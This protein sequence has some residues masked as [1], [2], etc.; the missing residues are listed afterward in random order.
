MCGIAGIL[1]NNSNEKLIEKFQKISNQLLHRGPD[2]SSFYK[3]S[4]N[5]FLHTRLSIIDLKGGKQPII[6]NDLILVANGE[7]Y[8]DPEIRSTYKTYNF[9]TESDSESI[10]TLYHQEGVVGLEKLR[11]MYAFAIYD[12]K[13]DCTILGRDIFGIKP[14]YF[15]LIN[16]GI[17]FSSEITPLINTKIIKKSISEEKLIEYFELQYTTG[18]KT[19]F[20]DIFR[21]RPGEIL[22]IKNGKIINSKLQKLNLL[23]KRSPNIDNKFIEKKLEESVSVH[24]RSDVP[25]CLFFSGGIDSMLIMYFMSKLNLGSK[26]E[27]FKVNIDDRKNNSN[28]TLLKKISHDYKIKFNEVSFTEDDFWNTIPFAAKKIDDPIADYA[29]LP[30]FKLAAVA[31]KKFKVA[32]TGEGGDELFGG[33]GRYRHHNFLKKNFFKGAFR[34]LGKFNNNYWKFETSQ[35][36]I[37]NLSLTRV[38]KQQ[39]FDYYNWLPNNLLV[40]LDRC[41]MTYG[42]EGRTP[43]IDRKLFENFFF[44][45]DNYKI[46]NGFGKF[47]IRNFIKSKVKYYDAFTKKEGFTIPIEK[48]LPK[49]SKFF[50]EFLPKI[51]ILRIFFSQDEI[52]E[53]CKSISHNKKAIRCV[54]HMIFISI[55]YY[56]TFNNVKANGNFFDIISS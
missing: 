4:K 21:L 9:K 54:W 55:W 45:K 10:M 38:Q 25:Y 1:L 15:S 14:L 48:W 18:K 31:S 52:K 56:V 13:K 44:I 49:H 53:L 42:M 2:S 33:Y 32:I 11:G 22:T 40:K 5:L 30:T 8:N 29:I 24:L 50:L 28:N 41:L 35:T 51:E 46:N 7:I 6:N 37:E 36:F 34:N 20:K 47:L 27:A 23:K 3:N 17:I 19:I 39:F 12:K 26:I 16:D 43:L